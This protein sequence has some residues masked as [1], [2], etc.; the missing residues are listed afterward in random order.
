MNEVRSMSSESHAVSTVK[1]QANTL[2]FA[3]SLATIHSNNILSN[4]PLI[5]QPSLQ[6]CIESISHAYGF[7][8]FNGLLQ[9]QTLGDGLNSNLLIQSVLTQLREV[10]SL[11]AVGFEFAS[12]WLKVNLDEHIARKAYELF[13]YLETLPFVNGLKQ[14]KLIYTDVLNISKYESNRRG[15]E[16]HLR[17]AE[18]VLSH[19]VEGLCDGSIPKHET[20][21]SI[22]FF[23]PLSRLYKHKIDGDL[24]QARSLIKYIVDDINLSGILLA[25]EG[26]LKFIDHHHSVINIVVDSNLGHKLVKISKA[27]AVMD[28]LLDKFH[29]VLKIYPKPVI[30]F[31]KESNLKGYDHFKYA[32]YKYYLLQICIG[33]IAK[34][35]EPVKSNDVSALVNQLS[36]NPNGKSGHAFSMMKQVLET[37]ESEE[38]I[39]LD[40]LASLSP[41]SHLINE[42]ITT[43]D[44]CFA[45]YIYPLFA[46]ERACM[47]E[48]KEIADLDGNVKKEDLLSLM[49]S[50]R[51]K[52][53]K[54]FYQMELSKIQGSVIAHRVIN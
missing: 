48:L 28:E 22:M 24:N 29:A 6:Q 1:Q 16:S 32:T 12:S 51:L 39:Y 21:D 15:T 54:E 19:V 36:Y 53:L 9:A 25:H 17:F 35:K 44:D 42:A 10:N 2:K 52:D 46:K 18:Y 7:K 30:D 4:E 13:V 26:E 8:S 40:M 41:H 20:E 23:L 33:L 31:K 27:K 50:E 37:S 3:F 47:A 45:R 38:L 14:P 34:D 5:H 11:D 49:H 43:F